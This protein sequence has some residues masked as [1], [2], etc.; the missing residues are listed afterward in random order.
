MVRDVCQVAM[1]EE[2]RDNSDVLFDSYLEQM[3]HKIL[4][5]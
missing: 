2:V 5:D 4:L 3:L 1:R